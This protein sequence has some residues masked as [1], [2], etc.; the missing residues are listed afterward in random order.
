M[1][2]ANAAT[3]VLIFDMAILLWFVRRLPTRPVMNQS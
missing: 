3:L 1:M 2:V